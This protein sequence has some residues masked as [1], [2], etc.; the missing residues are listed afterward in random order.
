MSNTSAEIKQQIM[1]RQILAFSLV[2]TSIVVLFLA[3]IAMMY[4]G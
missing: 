4:I 1:Q 2:G 3:L